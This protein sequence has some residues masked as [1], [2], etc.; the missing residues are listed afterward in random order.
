MKIYKAF[1]FDFFKRNGLQHFVAKKCS[2]S[3][4]PIFIA[5]I[6][7]RK[8]YLQ[9]GGEEIKVQRITEL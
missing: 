9:F 5:V 6:S 1:C 2:S 8:H 3:F 4:N 7:G